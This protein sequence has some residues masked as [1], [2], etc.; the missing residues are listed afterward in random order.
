MTAS[1]DVSRIAAEAVGFN[2]PAPA[3]TEAPTTTKEPKPTLYGGEQSHHVSEMQRVLVFRGYEVPVNG[4]YGPETQEAVKRYQKEMGLP[5][6]GVV[7]DATWFALAFPHPTTTTT[8]TAPPPTRP[9]TTA[10]PKPPPSPQPAPIFPSGPVSRAVIRLATQHVELY[11]SAGTMKARFAISSGAGGAT[12]RGSFRVF[13]KVPRA[14]SES[15]P[16]VSMPWMVNFNNGIGFH[17]IP[18]KGSKPLPTPLGRYP[19]SH[20]CIRM[21]DSHAKWLYDNLPM[22]SPVDVV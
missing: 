20:G 18:V 1:E 9:P 14:T 13:R 22:G 11:D 19:V 21:A 16:L 3:V 17:G 15:D 10:A 8:T 12:P 6:D 2:E 4:I 5:A 7:G